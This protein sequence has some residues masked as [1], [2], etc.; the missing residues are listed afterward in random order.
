[1]SSPSISPEAAATPKGAVVITGTSTGI[2]RA[3][4]LLLDRSGYRVFATVR[5]EAD[6]QSLRSEAS[7][8]LTPL[9]MDITCPDQ[10]AAAAQAV[11]DALGPDTG[12]RGLVNN[13]G[14]CEAGPI[15]AI[16]LDRFRQQMEVNVTAHVSVIQNFLPLI[17]QGPG[18]IIN[19]S[20]A[21]SLVPLP[22]LGGYAASKSAMGAMS[23]TLRREMCWWNIPVCI[24]E[25]GA[26]D[27]SIWE[28]PV[29]P[30]DYHGKLDVYETYSKLQTA[31]GGMLQRATS[32]ACRPGKP[33]ATIKR[34]LETRWPRARYRV[35][36]DSFLAAQSNKL[37]TFVVDWFIKQSVKKESRTASRHV[38]SM[39]N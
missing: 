34:A 37:P 2:G 9:M 31:A 29:T 38:A 4:A 23:D 39:R 5:K 26:V 6:A 17:R 21:I 3:T 13:A 32:L 7:D 35:G 14:G 33:A 25:P 30:D 18:R 19:I 15:E 22:W 10:V 28:T 12:L 20:S 24:I 27:T 11:R 1:M 8:A 36:F 16:G